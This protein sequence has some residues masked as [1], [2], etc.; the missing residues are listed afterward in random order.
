VELDEEGRFEDEGRGLAIWRKVCKAVDQSPGFASTASVSRRKEFV[1]S[2]GTGRGALSQ[3][4]KGSS[5][6][7]EAEKSE[8]HAAQLRMTTQIDQATNGSNLKSNPDPGGTW[9]H[10]P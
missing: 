6:P 2:R 7:G 3:F 10:Y 4:S 1:R 5:T 9:I 8:A